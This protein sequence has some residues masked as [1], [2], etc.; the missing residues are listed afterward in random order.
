MPYIFYGFMPNK[1]S[2]IDTFIKERYSYK[3][4]GLDCYAMCINV[5]IC[6][7]VCKIL[8]NTM[9]FFIGGTLNGTLLL[10]A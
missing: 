4:E 9:Q 10:F 6:M 2:S 3:F 1:M 7:K 8:T 5:Y